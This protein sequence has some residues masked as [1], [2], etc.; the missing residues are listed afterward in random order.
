MCQYCIIFISAEY[1]AK[2]W[3]NHERM[4]AQARAFNERKEYILPARFDDTRIPGL[5]D[6]VGYIDLS[7]TSPSQLSDLAAQ[8]L[9]KLTRMNYL[10]P[11]LDRLYERLGVPED[12]ASQREVQSHALS[13]LEVLCRMSPEEQNAV[14]T[15]IRYGCADGPP[16][17]AHINTDLLRRLTGKSIARLKRLL[18]GLGSLGFECSIDETEDRDM[19]IPG[20]RLGHGNLFYLTWMNLSVDAPDFP[21]IEVLSA[22]IEAATEDLCNECGEK[23]LSRLGFSQLASA[24]ASNDS[25]ETEG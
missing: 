14:I 23:A 16:E 3:T 10:P 18:G 19:E 17:N 21:E 20:S 1:A 24:T 13:F 5:L 25:H 8:K 7:N 12:H 2:V 11:T 6:T 22:M 15:L 9:G 4:S